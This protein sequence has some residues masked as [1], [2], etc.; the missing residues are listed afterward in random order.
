MWVG[1]LLCEIK[2]YYFCARE[3]QEINTLYNII[4]AKMDSLNALFQLSE[5]V[6]AVLLISVI[7]AAGIILGKLKVKGVSLGVTF[8]FFAG[9]MAG[10]CGLHA[11]SVMTQY[12]MD[13][14]LVL[15]VYSLGL[16]VGPGFLSAFRHGGAQLNFIGLA[17][18]LVGTLLALVCCALTDV[19]LPDMMGVLCGAT[20]NTPALGAAQQ[21]MAQ[22]GMAD[23]AASLSL[24]CAVTYPLG[25][26]GVILAFMFLRVFV[27][28]IGK[29]GAK[30]PPAEADA[31]YI[32]S[33][34]VRNVAVCGKSLRQVMRLAKIEFVVSRLWREGKVFLPTSE[35]VLEADDRILVITHRKDVD[36]L[37]VFFGERDA[38][39][40]NQKDVDWDKIDRQIV[41]K[42]V[43]ITR[44]EI[45]GKRLGAL[46]LR[47]RFSVNVS[48]VNRA[49]LDLVA[50]SDLVLC[51][52][53][54]I[55]VVGEEKA[56]EH[57]AGH[58]GNVV[59]N[60][61]E[62][63]LAAIFIGIVLG[64]LLGAIPLSIPS[65][66]VPVK[67][68]LAGGPIVVG[69]LVGAY[70]PRFHMVTYTT[71]SANRML[72]ALGLS[73]YLAC[74]GLTAGPRFF[75]T[76]V[77]ADGLLWVALGFLV[78][79]LPVVLVGYCALKFTKLE[80]SSVGGLLCG[81]MANP[82]ALG[83]VNDTSDANKASVAYTTVY[84]L[85]MFARVVVVQV[86]LLWSM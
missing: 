44:P 47:N 9:I 67:L 26:I 12:A 75:D 45:N 66:G 57:V 36:Y 18:V 40:W 28:R 14:G 22:I 78:T 71:N 17:V 1:N 61:D 50:T 21:A 10:Y 84:P 56:V 64:L 7:C 41:S 19:S 82:M 5:S 48:R 74:L 63:N 52:G 53:D 4:E 46:Q 3:E 80:L 60:L 29:N 2:K 58:L 24:G 62:P 68:G 54:R 6:S 31:P 76:V 69:I 43:V 16:Q 32:V 37:T 86:V 49:G 65:I 25:V 13:A 15:F 83:Y 72:R 11:N 20:T 70:G 73:I 35:T 34:H 55:T 23:K 27:R 33:F 30:E 81:S 59:A 85:C 51:M 77:G 79:V 42:R 8:V 38:T 39:D